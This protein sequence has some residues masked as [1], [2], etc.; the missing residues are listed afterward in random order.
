MNIV[1]P[2]CC[3]K[4]HESATLRISLVMWTSVCCTMCNSLYSVEMNGECILLDHTPYRFCFPQSSRK[5]P[6]DKESSHRLSIH[7]AWRFLPSITNPLLKMKHI[8]ITQISDHIG[9]QSHS[10]FFVDC[11]C[12]CVTRKD[13]EGQSIQI[14]PLK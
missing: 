1:K 5:M 4:I 9:Q 11:D 6:I 7:T 3:L 8:D 13:S 10:Q 2:L 12:P 14:E